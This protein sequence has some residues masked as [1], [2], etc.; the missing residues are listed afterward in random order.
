MQRFMRLLS[1]PG[2]SRVDITASEDCAGDL[3][4]KSF[5]VA[6]DNRW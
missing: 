5:G 2:R 6:D 1:R 3:A 4:E